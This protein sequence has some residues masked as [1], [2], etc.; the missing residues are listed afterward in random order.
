MADDLDPLLHQATRLRLMTL[1]VHNRD[2]PFT[3]L[4]DRLGTTPGNLDGHV[5]RLARAG[6]VGHGKRLGESGFHVRVWITP[7]GEAAFQAYL[8]ALRALLEDASS[9]QKSEERK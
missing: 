6:Y 9:A 4:Q 5:Q 2:A 8:G 1:L 7:E 3:W